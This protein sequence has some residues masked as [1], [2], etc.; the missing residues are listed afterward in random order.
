ML[1]LQEGDYIIAR[2]D[3]ICYIGK[4]LNVD[5]D[6]KDVQ[7]S[8]MVKSDVKWAT[9]YMYKWPNPSDEIWI[10]QSDVLHKLDD[11]PEPCGRSKRILYQLSQDTSAIIDSMNA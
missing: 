7:V 10:P 5:A 8:F 4:V 11:Q 6:D 3:N 1:E 9:R 2:Y